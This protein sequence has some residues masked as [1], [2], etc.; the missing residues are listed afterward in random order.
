MRARG[1]F[2]PGTVFARMTGIPSTAM[3]LP[4]QSRSWKSLSVPAKLFITLVVLSGL[5]TLMYGGIH[6]SSRNIA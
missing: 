5:G 3:A 6:Q 4:E 2:P 1:Y